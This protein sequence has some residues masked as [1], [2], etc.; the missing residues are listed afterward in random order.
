MGESFRRWPARYPP[1]PTHSPHVLFNAREKSNKCNQCEYASTWK[2]T[3]E[4]S[5]TNAQIHSNSDPACIIQQPKQRH[6]SDTL[7]SI[8][9]HNHV[10]PCYY[11][12]Q[13][14]HYCQ[15]E[16]YQTKTHS[17]HIP[18][19]CVIF[20]YCHKKIKVQLLESVHKVTS[21][22]FF[23]RVQYFFCDGLVTTPSGPGGSCEISPCPHYHQHHH[24]YVK[25]TR[26]ICLLDL[27]KDFKTRQK[28]IN[29]SE[30]R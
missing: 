1:A 15:Q 4:K 19:K 7:P 18:S 26:N 16:H 29:V 2:H 3:V 28:N 21:F 25:V 6:N 5:Q 9:T 22:L 11:G 17:T 27:K 30:F 13:S 24:H 10:T 12:T 14:Y 23:C 8:V 20:S